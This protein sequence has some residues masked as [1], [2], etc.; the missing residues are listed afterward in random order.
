M[1][2]LKAVNYLDGIY[3][4]KLNIYKNMFACMYLD[5][6]IQ[7]GKVEEQYILKFT[8]VDNNTVVFNVTNIKKKF[9]E[10]T[11]GD[12]NTRLNCR[13]KCYVNDTPE[14]CKIKLKVHGGAFGKRMRRL[15]FDVIILDGGGDSYDST[16]WNQQYFN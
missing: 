13:S 6:T 15:G 14:K 9:K 7:I 10:K 12:K 16:S 8:S 5:G 2:E 3:E 1:F 11:R 4:A